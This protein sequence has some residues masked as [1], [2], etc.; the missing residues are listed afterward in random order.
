MVAAVSTVWCA[1][2][3]RAAPRGSYCFVCFRIHKHFAFTLI[4]QVFVTMIVS[5]LLKP[6]L[7]RYPCRHPCHRPCYRPSY[8]HLI[9]LELFC[10][11]P[12]G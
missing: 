4:N 10:I 6:H 12:L 2:G 1:Q 11:S 7:C 5:K 8:P 3:V 9:C